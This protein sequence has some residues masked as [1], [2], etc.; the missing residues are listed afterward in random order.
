MADEAA[1]SEPPPS[2]VSAHLAER[3]RPLVEAFDKDRIGDL[4]DLIVLVAMADG[5]IDERERKAL[6][7]GIQAIIGS[8]LIPMIVYRLT[9][10]SLEKAEATSAEDLA[11]SVGEALSKSD[12][13]EDGLRIAITVALSSQDLSQ[14]ERNIL[15]AIARA[16]SLPSDKLDELVEKVR[17]E[18]KSL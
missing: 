8:D 11:Q 7:A 9:D 1:D 17:A 10:E 18:I 13:L 14:T 6:H 2:R 16:G 4:V 5:T 3:L 12:S 15:A